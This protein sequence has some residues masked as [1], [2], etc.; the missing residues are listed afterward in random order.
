MR[1]FGRIESSPMPEPLET[2]IAG[3]ATDVVGDLQRLVSGAQPLETAESTDMA[4]VLG[5]GNLAIAERSAAG[6]LFVQPEVPEQLAARGRDKTYVVTDDP[7]GAF[8]TA[9]S[10]L[11]P[12]RER[13][14]IGESPH[15][16]IHPNARIGARTNIHPGATITAGVVIGD[17]CEVG[18]GVYIGHEARIG[19]HVQLHPNVVLYHDVI[20]GDRVAIQACSVIGADGFGYRQVDGRHER[21]HHF[22][23]VRIED[24]VDIG[25]CT[26]IDRALIG[27]TV[28]G[29]GTK[30]DNNVVI[31]H[32]CRLGEHNLLVSQVGFAGSVT[33]GDN[34]VCA[35]QVGV[36]DH[37]HIGTG[38]MLGA[39][40]GVHKDLA[41]G[42]SY[43]GAPAAPIAEMAR[44]V[45]A[46][47]KLPQLRQNVRNLERQIAELQAAVRESGVGGRES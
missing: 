33:T 17:D 26:T 21:L 43:L 18:A 44:S 27:E 32:N 24:D 45:M 22:G 36:A 25:A 12:V 14:S 34:V 35:G 30:I 29:R 28:I 10:R 16:Y 47:Q 46:L 23:T 19:D 38:A 11:R 42:K 2:L 13:P 3:V 37:V 20:I 15:A 5:K 4:F 1:R 41:G 8:F 9:L 31:A 6:V 7:K 39:K 40:A